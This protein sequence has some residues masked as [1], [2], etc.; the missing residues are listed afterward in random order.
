MSPGATKFL[1]NGNHVFTV[2]S[3]ATR[4]TGLF[5]SPSRRTTGFLGLGETKF[6]SISN[7]R[8]NRAAGAEDWRWTSKRQDG[9][10]K[11]IEL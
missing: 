9:D 3:S 5:V 6:Q 1:L 10:I 8:K 7:R 11:E 4:T 2:Q